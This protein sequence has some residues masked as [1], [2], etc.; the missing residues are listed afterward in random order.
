MKPNKKEADLFAPIRAY[1]HDRG[2]VV[3]AEVKGY[4]MTLVKQDPDTKKEALTIIEI[5]LHFNMRLIYQAIAAQRV[6]DF[7]YVA[8]PSQ[9][10]KQL[11]PMTHVARA[12][13]LGLI[14]VSDKG[15]VTVVL[16]ELDAHLASRPRYHNTRKANRVKKE[17]AQRKI[18]TNVGG[19]RGVKLMTAY[20]EKSIHIALA[21]TH[22]HAKGGASMSANGLIKAYG[23]PPDTNR[24]MYRHLNGWFKRLAKGQYALD[25]NGQEALH[26]PEYAQAV[27]FYEGLLDDYEKNERKKLELEQQ[28]D[29]IT[30]TQPAPSKLKAK[31]KR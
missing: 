20:R 14:T 6:A 21:L 13:G 30:S 3:N 18:D 12:L 24:I 27:K 28:A 17:I 25:K 31:R 1:W 26:L 10:Y 19:S 9:S 8:V 4:D 23:C 5:K 11:A 29:A 2:Y 16:G 15:L 22:V 7:V